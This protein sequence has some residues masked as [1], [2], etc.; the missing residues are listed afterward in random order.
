MSNSR[1]VL[2]ITNSP[3]SNDDYKQQLEQDQRV[4]YTI[5]SE[6]YNI[7]ILTSSQL[8][9]VDGI[10]LESHCPY[11]NSI[12][13]LRQLKEQMGEQCPPIIVID[14]GNIETAVQALKNGA[15]DYLVKDQIKPEDLC[16][17][18]QNAIENAELK[19]K[20]QQCQE[21][22]QTSVEN[23]LDC[24]GIFS[25][26]R[27]ESGEILDFR[28]DYLNAAACENN[29]M[30]K[31]MQIGRGLCEILPGHRE[32]SLFEEYCQLV[33]TGEPLIKDSLIYE[34]SYGD[35]QKLWRAFEIRAGKLND[36]F[37]AS[38]RDITD[39]KGL[40]LELSRKLTDLQQQ[41][42]RL[43]RLIDTAPMGIGVGSANGEVRVINDVMLK[44]HGLTRQEFEQQGM[45]WR[46]FV[47]PELSE[48]TEQAIEELR[49]QGF[50]SPEEKE[51][52]RKDGTRLPIWISTMQWLDGT[53]EHVAFAV[54]LTQRKQTE[55]AI[56]KVKEASQQRY[57]ELA[58]AMPQIIW[59]ADATGMVNYW[60]QHWY[61]YTGLS[62]AESMGLAK[63]NAVHPEDRDRTQSQW[64]Q[65]IAKEEPLAM[66]YRMRR[67]DGEYHWFISR[68]IPT[69]D[70]QGQLT[71][72]IGTI[73]DIND[74]KQTELALLEAHIQL[75]SALAAGSIYPWRWNVPENLVITDHNFA[76]L[77][78]IDPKLAVLG[79]PIE[80]FLNAIHPEDRP[81]V[82][83][84]IER[85]IATGEE[86]RAEF[87]IRNAE[88]EERWVIARGRVEYDADG[89]AI[90]FP[91]ALADISER[92]QVEQELKEN[93]TRF[94][95]LADNISQ[96]AWMTDEK[97]WIFWYNQRWFDYTG[98]TLEEM[99]GW[100]WQKVHH[101][102]HVE[103]VVER[104]RHC[105][106]TGTV[107][108]DTFP[109]RG[110][111]GEYRWFL[112]RAIPVRDS[113]GRVLQWFGTNTDI[114]ELRETKINLQQTTEQLNLA[115]KSAPL[116]LFN[117]DLNLRY[118]WIYNATQNFSVEEVIG[119]RDQ[120]LVSPESA[121]QLN[122]L[123]QQVLD[124]GIG[125]R[126]EVKISKDKQT[127][128]YDLTI[129]PIKDS[130]N[131]IVGITGAAVDIS[132][133]KQA[134]A[135]L[136]ESEDRLR[137]AIEASQLGTWDWNLIT[138]ELTWDVGCKA[139]FGLPPD[140]EISLEVF[141]EGL[142]PDD[143][144]LLEQT[145]QWSL[146]PA[147]GGEHD[148][149]Y[150]TIGIHDRIERWISAKG[151]TYFD[152]LGK[153]LRFIGT[154]LDITEQKQAQVQR[155]QLLEQEQAAREAAERANRIKDEFLA[156][157]SHE[158][159]SPLNPILGW[160]KLLQTYQLDKTKIS[161]GLATIERNV[162]LLTQLIDDLL[163]LAK[164]LR[165][166]LHLNITSVNLSLVIKAAIETV[167][168]TA[169][170]KSISLHPVLP[171]IG[172]VSG[173]LSRLQQIV[174]NLLSN[175]IKF[176]PNGGRVDIQLERVGNQ[177][178][179]KVSDT[180][181]GIC[182]DFLPHIF[183]SFRQED[184]SITRQY[185]GLG[186]GLAIV[187]QLVEAHGGSIEADSPGEGL[188]A[189]FTVRLPLLKVTPEIQQGDE[190]SKPKLDLTGIR[191]L[192]VDDE[193]DARELL[194]VLLSQ[195]G[196][197]VLTV[198]SGKEVLA[199]LESFQPDVLISD[200]GMPEVDGYSLIQRIRALPATQGGQIP[201]IALSAYG[202]EE[203]QQRS[204]NSGYQRHLVKPIDP[205]KLVKTVVILM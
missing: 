75:E 2:V 23:M 203:E 62:E 46:D 149:E 160:T 79:L 35:E 99:E 104:I 194:T 86:Y 100:G 19:R 95:T 41:Q 83:L 92:K 50:T 20:I 131:V 114:T 106:E 55:A 21:L 45:N 52:L 157:L 137:M 108:E 180:G 40:E 102:D 176:T 87:R 24:F 48:H 198:A 9:Q 129:D 4:A 153:P 184:A 6:Q 37:V 167:R 15:V 151:Q 118:T 16:L 141:F 181:K 113:Q 84:D 28:I 60:N 163:D 116:S 140:A 121:A 162:N 80:Q 191:V 205:E 76:H 78:G 77:F 133:R 32:S 139:M 119:R 186:L 164:I 201:A 170:A 145:I 88:G 166:K 93:E 11:L 61:E 156:V 195:Y 107:W 85:A 143:H 148:L 117:Q 17:A 173:D 185:G 147:N 68:A 33:E 36:G 136:R 171:D 56:Q 44:L 65:A 125:L 71:G 101:P 190:L 97:G 1:T 128:Y 10:I 26:I 159:R 126:E 178:Q 5:L 7:S 110:K 189:T 3:E 193:P 204:L 161:K 199:N 53:D 34:D 58:E 29:R 94:R 8:Q 39:R 111:D 74:H 25:A 192:V 177:A 132:D 127:A 54:D 81:Q 38:W 47:P 187:H 42:S 115:L 196:A 90:A 120:D 144:E 72:W 73:T 64:N 31:E 183:E 179:I 202:R 18:M 123:K 142:H 13:L 155:E 59:T 182:P 134:E 69:R 22:F 30:P 91:G 67:W 188:G 98:T 146:D 158:L 152:A 27:D 150:R 175:A 169:V 174:C 70:D 165:G 172:Q 109:L 12:E 168:T 66:E 89:K 63:F 49:I 103:R 105:F 14:S 122:Q 82:S 135:A 124:T 43:Q 130:Q 197:E 51:L 154:V 96:F 57:Q 138:N 112:S 200:L